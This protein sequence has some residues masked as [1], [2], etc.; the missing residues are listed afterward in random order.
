MPG[1]GIDA[2][3]DVIRSCDG[4]KVKHPMG[5]CLMS[6][7]SAVSPPLGGFGTFGIVAQLTEVAHLGEVQE[8]GFTQLQPEL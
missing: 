4:L 2:L 5:S 7:A 8:G 6:W 3:E 1:A